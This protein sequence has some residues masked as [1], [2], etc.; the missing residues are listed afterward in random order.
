MHYSRLNGSSPVLDMSSLVVK[1]LLC[2]PFP[3]L[4]CFLQ[5][6]GVWEL[7]VARVIHLLGSFFCL[8]GCGSFHFVLCISLFFFGV[9]WFI[10]DWQAL[11]I[12]LFCLCA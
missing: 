4:I 9:L 5:G 2:L 1:I 3:F 6:E 7:D 11:I 10:Y 12:I 8:L